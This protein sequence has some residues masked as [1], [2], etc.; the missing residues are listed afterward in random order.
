MANNKNNALLAINN[1]QSKQTVF[2]HL[3]QTFETIIGRKSLACLLTSEVIFPERMSPQVLYN[4]T[5]NH[6]KYSH[7]T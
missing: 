6:S 1:A 7:S 4:F 2:P 3:L 5:F